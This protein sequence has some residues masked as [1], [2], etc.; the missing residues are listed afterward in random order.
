[1]SSAVELS[2]EQSA[3]NHYKAFIDLFRIKCK[4]NSD[5]IFVRY[6]FNNAYKTLTYAECDRITTNLACK[7]AAKGKG[8]ECISLIGDHSVDYLIVMLTLLKLRSTLLAVSPRNSEPAI[9]NLL[10]KTN[11]KLLLA[12]A[13][14]E[15]IAQSAAAKVG[16]VEVITIEPLN[17]EELLL[18]PLVPEH[19]KLLD[20]EFTDAD[21]EKAALIIHSSGT[22]NFPKPIYL[23]NRG[24][25]YITGFPD[26][27]KEKYNI[28]MG[29][30]NDVHL[31][32]LPLFHLFGVFGLAHTVVTGASIVLLERLP[33][34]QKEIDFALRENKVTVMAAPPVILEQMIPFLKESNDF[35]A[36]RRLKYVFFGGA[37]LKREAGHWLYSHG[38]NIRNLYGSTEMGVALASNLNP[39]SDNWYSLGPY[40][41]D[42]D[43]NPYFVFEDAGDGLKHLY[44]RH[45]SPTMALGVSNRSGGGFDSN[46]LF[47]EDPDHP[48]F[49]I[50]VGR[51]DDTLIMENGE[52]TNPVPMETTIR[53]SPMVKQ[54][55]VIG[56]GRQCTAALVEVDL[57]YAMNY[58]PG[59]IISSVHEAVE[60]ANKECPSHSTILPQMVKILPF[61]K[62]LPSTDKGTVM[63]KKAEAIYKDL[64]DQMYQEFLDGP[65][66][67]GTLNGDNATPEQIESFLVKAS[68]EVLRLP[69]SAFN[70]Y[71]RSL[72]DIGLN[73]LT[74]IQLRNLISKQFGNV[75]Q[76]FLFQNPSIYAIRDALSSNKQVDAAELVET[77]YQET[78]ELA[79][80]YIERAK[81]DFLVAE[82]HYDEAQDKV[83]LL[84]GATGSLGSFMLRDLLK[85][86]SVKKIYCLVRGKQEGLYQRLVS[87]FKSRCLDVSLLNSDRVEALPMRMNEPYLGL[88]KEKYEQLRNE[89]TIVQHCAWLLDFNMTIGH[90]DKECISPFYNLLKFAYREVNPMHVYFVSSISAS[91]ASGAVVE[92][93][94]LRF[95]S[96]VAMPMGYAQ[97]KFV[98]EMLLNY[99]TKEKNFPC[100]VE[101]LGQ[102][103]GDAENGVW[104][105]SEQFP[106]MFIAGGSLMHK[107]PRFNTN[108]D[109]IPVDYAATAMVD[110][111][112][113]TSCL[114]SRLDDSI[115][116]IVN[117]RNIKW[118]DIL[119]NMRSCGMKFE[120]VEPAE[121]IETLSKDDTNPAYRLMSFYEDMFKSGLR[122]PLWETTKTCQTTPV[123]GKSPVL[124]A[125][126]FN[127]Y[128]KHWQSVGFYN[129]TN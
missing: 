102:A 41:N 32:C 108:I 26:I 129:S 48:G 126:L 51:R 37:P 127:K 5:R 96:H 30:V 111:M 13:K 118:S 92:E 60:D 128:L 39:S 34:S 62:H 57:E 56:H 84:T 95:D 71:S 112:L 72:F 73:S 15:S 47:K 9:I 117:P 86:F 100:Y 70:D 79:K 27:Y 36:V 7:W 31:Y 24:L 22:T 4:L 3:N 99:L 35:S 61:S 50:Y 38:I 25:L 115:Y 80:R 14:H 125:E 19:D 105:T 103:C 17:I 12:T 68:S 46:D 116:H 93:K 113:R 23:S 124:D 94:P 69:E 91:A 1:M 28:Q 18:E 58:E 104:N 120:T 76:N 6:Y 2:S 63:R 64:I 90:Y 81:S 59:E 107:M 16:G 44:L 110:I 55:A 10:E 77:R 106:L 75:P 11:S 45:G 101:R 88:T 20:S 74:A 49:Y 42:S 29:D 109:W 122:M 89:V 43:G 121:W 123:L 97:S 82:E 85:D 66:S 54:V 52:K 65:R 21:L 114:P 53:S 78:Q 33:P 67:N 98:C 40:L 87:S 83:V 119:E 8:V